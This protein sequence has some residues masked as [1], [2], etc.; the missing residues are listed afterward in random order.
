MTKL[1]ALLSTTAFATIL[2][3]TPAVAQEAPAEASD[4]TEIVVTAQKR[5]ESAQKVP[6][7]LTVL[8]GDALASRHLNSI[9]Q[10]TLAAPSLQ[11]GSD[12]TFAI[13]G[14]G[15]LAFSVNLNSSVAI[16]YDEVNLG[17]AGLVGNLFNDLARVEVLNG[18]QGLLFGKNAT[19]GLLNVVTAKPKLG[20]AGMSFDAEYDNRDSLP[21]KSHGV[22]A[23]AMVNLPVT[24]N[25][26]LRLNFLYDYQ[27]PITQYVGGG[28]KRMDVNTRNFGIR[29]KYL[30]QPSDSF[31]AYF[32]GEYAEQHGIA[33]YFDRTYRAVGSDSTNT[34]HIAADGVVA[35]VNNLKFA[36]DGSDFRNSEIGGAQANLTYKFG[37]GMQLTNIAAWKYYKSESQFDT[38]FT[39]DNGA[40]LNHQAS[41]YDQFSN[42]LRLSTP[43]NQPFFGQVGLF[44]MHS[45]ITNDFDL[46]RA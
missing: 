38:D 32:I 19:S 4:P 5:S 7:S 14:V 35:G 30:I 8:S 33:G 12:N 2:F 45:K 42:E 15:T 9:D 39:R 29:G 26:A 22:F 44:Y 25:S 24:S 6:V 16:S 23:R 46:Q 27:Q 18:P 37:N 17:K 3:A 10:I 28:A 41:K 34:P 40:S 36:A 31:E 21:T 43:A 11:L 20:E 1:H 13:R